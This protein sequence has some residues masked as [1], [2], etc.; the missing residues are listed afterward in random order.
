M[1]EKDL[2]T[3]RLTLPEEPG[4]EMLSA[5][6][7]EAAEEADTAT[8]QTQDRCFSENQSMLSRKVAAL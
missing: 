7:K 6:M 2:N 1:S 3:Y 4:D 8:A 5:I